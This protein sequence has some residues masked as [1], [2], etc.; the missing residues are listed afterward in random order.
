MFLG[1]VCKAS[2]SARGNGLIVLCRTVFYPQESHE[3]N[4]PTV[5][6]RRLLSR[7]LTTRFIHDGSLNKWHNAHM[8]KRG[9]RQQ[10]KSS[11][12]EGDWRSKSLRRHKELL[13]PEA[14]VAPRGSECPT[15]TIPGI[16]NRIA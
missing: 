6:M 15:R 1:E 7:G 16:I 4:F 3:S 11:V 9:P 12:R 14:T 5:R 2:Q 10:T 8:C 13:R